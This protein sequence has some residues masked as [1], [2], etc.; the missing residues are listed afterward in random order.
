MTDD[1]EIVFALLIGVNSAAIIWLCFERDK[2]QAQI[3]RMSMKVRDL[4]AK[5]ME[6][7]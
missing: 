2:M 5:W 6:Q 3:N 4:I 1:I 7:P